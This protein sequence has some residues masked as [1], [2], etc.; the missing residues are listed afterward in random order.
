MFKKEQKEWKNAIIRYDRIASKLFKK[1]KISLKK[2]NLSK[3][4]SK[5]LVETFGKEKYFLFYM[6]II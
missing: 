6:N 5:I 1:I 2:K 4:E 3:E